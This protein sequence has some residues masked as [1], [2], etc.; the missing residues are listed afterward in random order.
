VLPKQERKSPDDVKLSP[1][2]P[3]LPGIPLLFI[4][5]MVAIG[6]LLAIPEIVT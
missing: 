4:V 2:H 6:V 5:G 1:A 3:S